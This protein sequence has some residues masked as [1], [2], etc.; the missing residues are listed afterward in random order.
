MQL[1]QKIQKKILDSI[2]A[3]PYCVAWKVVVANERGVPDIIACIQGKFVAIEVKRPNEKPTKLQEAQLS[4]VT[5]A[6]GL[7]VW[8]SD[9]KVV[10]N[11][12]KTG[13]NND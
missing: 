8:G 2:N 7:G 6:K 9:A 5:A 11:L 13:A 4:R 12:I 1:E 3:M 10:I